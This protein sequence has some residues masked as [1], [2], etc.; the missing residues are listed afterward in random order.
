MFCISFF[1]PFLRLQPDCVLFHPSILS[2]LAPS[3]DLLHSRCNHVYL[4]LVLRL[5][6]LALRWW[7]RTVSCQMSILHASVAHKWKSPIYRLLKSPCI[8]GVP[9]SVISPLLASFL[10][11][12]VVILSLLLPSV[13]SLSFLLSVPFSSLIVP[14]WLF[15]A[16]VPVPQLV[17]VP[18]DVLRAKI[19]WVFFRSICYGF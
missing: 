5:L 7:V 10:W 13:V 12:V 3:C 8:P 4:R 18:L 6:W 1:H 14:P 19:V 2:S 16:L 11:F 17:I 15:P 9:W